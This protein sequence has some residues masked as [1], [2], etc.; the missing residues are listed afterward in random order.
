EEFE[1]QDGLYTLCVKGIIQNKKVEEYGINASISRVLSA[2]SQWAEVLACACNPDMKVVISNTT[3]IGICLDEQEDIRSFPPRSFPGKLLACLYQ[4]FTHFKGNP[5]MGWVIIPT[6]LIKENGK[7]LKQILQDL[8]RILQLEEAFITWLEEANYFCDS[9]VDRIVPGKLPGPVHL[10]TE[11]KLGYEDQLMIMAEPYCLWAI[12]SGEPRVRDILSFQKVDSGVI[13]A[14]QIHTFR[15]LKLRLLNGTHTLSCGLAFLSGFN[16]V[17]AAMENKQM[18]TF[19]RHL[20]LEEIAP[21]I[22]SST[23]TREE[24]MAFSLQVLDRFSNPF[25]EHQWLNIALQVSS[26]MKMRNLPVLLRHYEIS[27]T[28]PPCIALGFAA[29]LLF[30]KSSKQEDGKYYGSRY[31]KKY[32]LQDESAEYYSL[33]WKDKTTG[34]VVQ[35]ILGDQAFWGTDCRKL[36]GFEQAVKGYLHQLLELEAGEV[37]GQLPNIHNN[38]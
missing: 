3:E 12:E 25:I 8:T 33:H 27:T 6:E 38:H 9:L 31:G 11:K 18:S 21:A 13:I 1:K 17:K 2:S 23:I 26:K 19:I 32:L 5:Q 16:T 29:H 35:D 28:P 30:M 34:R 10:A 22:P 24:A 14:P 7:K 15:E 37:L 4:R 36:P 20:M